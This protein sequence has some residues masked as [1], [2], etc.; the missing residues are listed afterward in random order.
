MFL[1]LWISI[2]GQ[3]YEHG[4]YFVNSFEISN[5]KLFS[6]GF[7]LRSVTDK[8]T[9]VYLLALIIFLALSFLFLDK[10][11]FSC[12]TGNFRT[13]R[14]IHYILLFLLGVYYA[15][16][17]P[18]SS[19]LNVTNLFAFDYLAITI[20]IIAVFFSFQSAVIFNDICD[21]EI[22]KISNNRRPLVRNEISWH[23]YKTLGIVFF[24]ISIL[25][26]FCLH[27]TIFTLIIIFHLLAYLYSNPPFRLR[28]V[29]LTGN[30]ILAFISLIVF[31]CGV[32]LISQDFPSFMVIPNN[33]SISILI[34]LF[35]IINIKDL[36]DFEG[37]KSSNIVSLITAIGNKRGKY[38]ISFLVSLICIGLPVYFKMQSFLLFSI[39]VAAVFNVN[40]FLKKS[41]EEIFFIIYYIYSI[42]FFYFLVN[43]AY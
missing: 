28:N 34:S 17:K 18:C 25:A 11:K 2:W 15:Y 5:S 6:Q 31:H 10:K 30:M 38:V 33:I 3:V 26:A 39:L 8:I 7:T 41:K 42:V 32:S 35:V 24:L 37:D 19:D 20:G 16:K 13:T 43:N 4:W 9:A 14:S 23:E 12:I 22:D 1:G 27:E 29:F 40:L 36:K 21:I